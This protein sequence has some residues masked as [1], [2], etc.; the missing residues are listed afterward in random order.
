MAINPKDVKEVEIQAL[1]VKRAITT[2]QANSLLGRVEFEE[3]P[4]VGGFWDDVGTA[5]TVIFT[6]LQGI[7]KLNAEQTKADI[8]AASARANIQRGGT[9]APLGPAFG[10]LNVVTILAFA[11]VGLLAVVLLSSRRR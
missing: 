7:F 4:P 8:L 1:W 5:S 9:A 2:A 10:G 6:G 11:G 3:R